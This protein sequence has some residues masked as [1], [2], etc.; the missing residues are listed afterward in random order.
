[1][2][3]SSRETHS[4]IEGVYNLIYL[5]KTMKAFGE[6]VIYTLRPGSYAKGFPCAKDFGMP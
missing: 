4:G 3:Y 2:E 1:M 5:V 6:M